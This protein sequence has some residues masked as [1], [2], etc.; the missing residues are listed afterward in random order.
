[1]FKKVYEVLVPS[2]ENSCGGPFHVEQLQPSIQVSGNIFNIYVVNVDK[3]EDIKNAVNGDIA[4]LLSVKEY[5][6]PKVLLDNKIKQMR[7]LQRLFQ[8]N[9]KNISIEPD[10]LNLIQLS[11]G[12]KEAIKDNVVCLKNGL[13]W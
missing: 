9:T 1:M 4:T 12:D 7:E 2:A 13:K 5:N 10:I 11:F 8:K 6:F 3:K